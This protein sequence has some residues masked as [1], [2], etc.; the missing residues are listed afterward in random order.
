MEHI[1][2]SRRDFKLGYVIRLYPETWEVDVRL[3]HDTSGVVTRCKV[4]SHFLPEVHKTDFS[5]EADESRLSFVLLGRI[6]AY[7]QGPVAIPIH[8]PIAISDSDKGQYVYWSEHLGFRV[9]IKQDEHPKGDRTGE[10]EIRNQK[11]DRLL[12]IRILEDRAVIRLDTP[13]TR[14]IMDDTAKGITI[15]CDEKVQVTCKNATVDA[16]EKVEVNCQNA[17]VAASAEA[18]VESPQIRLGSSASAAIERAV[19]GEQL[20]LYI[21]SHRHTDVDTG[22]GTSGP[23]SQEFPASA[24]SAITKL[25]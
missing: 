21:D 14:I 3:V 22:T 16:E 11:D 7:Q 20:K 18:D 4:A 9:T 5:G 24:L 12:Q 13:T 17:V 2:E 23:P 19:L 25:E 6:D 8:H 10:L 15:E 1:A